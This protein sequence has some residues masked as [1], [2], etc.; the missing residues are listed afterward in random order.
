MENDRRFY[1]TVKGVGGEEKIRGLRC[2][3]KRND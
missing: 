3:K 1:L 2:D